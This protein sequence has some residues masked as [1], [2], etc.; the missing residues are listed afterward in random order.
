MSMNQF[1]AVNALVK[2]IQCRVHDLKSQVN[3]CWVP[4]HVGVP[5]NE[6]VDTI[7]RQAIQNPQIVD[8]QLPRSDIKSMIK[9]SCTRR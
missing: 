8:V 5:M 7:A 6:R 4:A 9:S 3:F 1:P 2:L